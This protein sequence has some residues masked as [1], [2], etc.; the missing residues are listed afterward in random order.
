MSA[1]VDEDDFSRKSLKR[2]KKKY[3]D[4]KRRITKELVSALQDPTVVVMADWLKI[5]GALKKW[6]RF[7]C[8]LKPGLLIIY[9]NKKADR[10]DWVGTVLLNLC[11]LIE[12]PSKKDGFCFK[13]Y[14]PMDMSIWG[15]RG[16]LG[17]SYGSFSLNPL[18]TSHLICRASSDQVGRCWMDALELSFKCT[19]L[20]KRTM[21]KLGEKQDDENGTD[22]EENDQ[23]TSNDLDSDEETREERSETDAERHFREIDEA[24]QDD[25]Q[26]SETSEN[27]GSFEESAWVQS[28]K[29]TFG[30]GSGDIND[31]NKSII[32]ALLKQLRPGMDLSKV[33]LPTFIL[34]PRSYL[35]KLSDFHYHA[36]M[37]SEAI[38]AP[39]PHQ[40]M[41]KV[42]KYVL[43]GFYKKPKGLKKP[44]NP[45]LGESFRCRWDHPDG[46]STF[47]IAEQVSHHPP[48]TS[49]YI[50]NRKVGFNINA[51]ILAKSKFYGNS[52]AALLIGKI[53]LTLLNLGETYSLDLPYVYCKNLLVGTATMEHGGEIKIECSKTGYSGDLEFH[54]KPLIGG[55]PN[56]ISG[57]IKY[58]SE[59]I[60]KIEGYW[61]EHITIKHTADKKT[62][63]LWRV[64]PETYE[65]RLPR[66]EIKFEDQLDHE[67][68]KLWKKV[69]EAIADEDQEQATIEKTKLEDAQRERAKSG[70]PHQQKYFKK[71]GDEYE[72]IYADYR[73]WDTNNDLRQVESNYIIRTIDKT[74]KVVLKKKNKVTHADSYDSVSN[75]SVDIERKKK[76]GD[77]GDL[78]KAVKELQQSG[79]TS[80][81]KLQAAL[82]QGFFEER[83]ARQKQLYIILFVFTIIHASLVTLFLKR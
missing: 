9:K 1:P 12:R 29:E 2:Q 81:R 63:D 3:R 7:Y 17:Q 36:D 57:H 14:H 4:E 55:K 42:M 51:T 48:I 53:N 66:F 37:L 25:G 49:F 11:E 64:T 24:E 31:Q 67:S 40:R 68:V 74:E 79:E 39:D 76:R 82:E 34:E 26:K 32:W 83:N 71:V 52:M 75:A 5:R 41:I 28:A 62:E 69:S 27:D 20:L 30:T 19:G 33:T 18:N 21:N 43:S 38:N 10:G 65:K 59:T 54:L 44:Y 72:Y 80:F 56:K 13:L 60:S 73:P 77:E 8:V 47:Y 70:V 46:S 58:G 78:E 50:T 6:N 45:I 61:D 23:P 35:E 15:N 16:P 22:N